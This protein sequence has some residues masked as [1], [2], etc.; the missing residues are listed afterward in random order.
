MPIPVS[1]T[2]IARLAPARRVAILASPSRGVN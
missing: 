2:L 1:L